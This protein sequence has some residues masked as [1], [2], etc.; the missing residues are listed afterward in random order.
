MALYLSALF[1]KWRSVGGG[2]ELEKALYFSAIW[3]EFQ[4]ITLI[5]EQTKTKT[6]NS[7]NI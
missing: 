7:V 6:A 3:S 1:L 5:T 4:K 2:V